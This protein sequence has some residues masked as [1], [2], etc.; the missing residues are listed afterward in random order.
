MGRHREDQV[1]LAEFSVLNFQ[2]LYTKDT[3]KRKAHFIY[4]FL[5]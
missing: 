3:E 1:Y 4:L 2:K 5:D